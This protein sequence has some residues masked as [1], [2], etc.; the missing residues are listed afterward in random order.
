[1]KKF[2][3]GLLIC[4][5]LAAAVSS[6]PK[7]TDNRTVLKVS[8]WGSRTEYDLMKSH[9]AEFEALNPDVRVEFIHVPENYFRKIHL[10]F[11]AKTPPDVIFVNNTRIPLYV[12]AGLL[13]PLDEVVDKKLFF[14]SAIDSFTFENRLYAVPRDVSGLVLFCNKDIFKSKKVPVPDKKTSLEDF[15]KIAKRLSTQGS[16]ALNRETDPM[17][18][19]TF[20]NSLGGKILDEN[21]ELTINS[22]ALT[23]GL[24]LYVDMANIDRSVPQAPEMSGMT[25]AQMFLEGKIAMLLSG[26]WMVPILR[27]NAR[28]DWDVTEFPNPSNYPALVDSSGWAVAKSSPRKALAFKFIKFSVSKESDFA[29]TGLITPALVSAAN[30]GDFSAPGMPPKNAEIFVSMLENSAPTPVNAKYSKI[31]DLTVKTSE[32]V[33]SGKKSAA[34]AFS[35]PNFLSRLNKFSRSEK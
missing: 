15:R 3:V 5:F 29:K 9:I 8:A 7:N 33:F 16:F 26:R 11:A 24:Q 34:D 13:E 32:P 35:D 21:G 19:L 12:E 20:S 31:V 30:S 17:F 4:G 2:L 14:K 25:S 28:F 1:M 22:S 6:V 23:D 27:R 18:W 10:L